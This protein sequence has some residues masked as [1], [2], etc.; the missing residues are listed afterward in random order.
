MENMSFENAMEELESIV[1][2]LEACS[3]TLDE[4]LADFER[5]TALVKFCNDQLTGAEKKIEILT[6]GDSE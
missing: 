2:R 5:A 3:G 6:G 4:S 1:K